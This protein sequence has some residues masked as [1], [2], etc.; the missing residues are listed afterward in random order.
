MDRRR[1]L[2]VTAVTGA[3]AAL[4]S[5]GHPENQIIRFIPDDEIVPGMATWKP[6]ICP[7][8]PAGCGLHVRVMDADVD[9]VRN[10][11]RGVVRAAVAK[12]L[13]G[14]PAHPVNRGS[15]VRAWP[16][17]DPGDLSPGSPAASDEAIGR[18]RQRPISGS[19]LGRGAC[20]ADLEARCAG[21]GRS[22]ACAGVSREAPHERAR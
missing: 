17:G 10:G 19:E 14:L 11:Q 3:S 18:A 5:C 7:L 8:C 4:A 20:R 13:E 6:S 21:R 2:K 15:V 9:V 16:G 1:F 22:D 12:K